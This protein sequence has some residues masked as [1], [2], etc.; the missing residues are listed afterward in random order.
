MHVLPSFV[1]GVF[2]SSL[3]S[4]GSVI[5]KNGLINAS[6][7]FYAGGSSLYVEQ[8]TGNVGIGTASPTA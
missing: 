6:G 3:V 2:A 1:F 5:V 7:N 4:G 8:S